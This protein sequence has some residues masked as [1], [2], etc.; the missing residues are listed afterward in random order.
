MGLRWA[1]YDYDVLDTPIQS[2]TGREAIGLSCP[3]A[4]QYYW[5]QFY[6]DTHVDDKGTISTQPDLHFWKIASFDFHT[7]DLTVQYASS[8]TSSTAQING[9]VG[10]WLTSGNPL[11]Q[12]RTHPDDY[13]A[14]IELKQKDSATTYTVTTQAVPIMKKADHWNYLFDNLNANI[15]IVEGFDPSL[16][17]GAIS[18]R[19]SSKI[20]MPIEGGDVSTCAHEF[21]HGIARLGDWGSATC[22]LPPTP[23][24]SG[25]QKDPLRNGDF[26]YR[27]LIMYH[28][29]DRE[30]RKFLEQSD[31]A[32]FQLF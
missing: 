7:K 24:T 26:F 25:C 30:D 2:G 13:R 20:I 12:E 15:I 11:L 8:L 14:L 17:M 22:C 19:G 1:I 16:D 5:V 18:R 3:K 29:S 6:I 9:L 10:G 31:A 21:G 28:S 32:A 23:G 27:S 4:P